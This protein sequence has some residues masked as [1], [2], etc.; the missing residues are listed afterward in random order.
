MKRGAEMRMITI[1]CALLVLTVASCRKS[2]APEKLWTVEKSAAKNGVSAIFRLS[3]VTLTPGARLDCELDVQAPAATQLEKPQLNL[4]G[5]ELVDFVALPVSLTSTGGEE[6][7]FRWTYQAG[8]PGSV[9][10]PSVCVNFISAQAANSLS[11]ELPAI[12]IKSA[13]APG[14]FTD[15]LPPLEEKNAF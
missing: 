7:K 8:P 3:A 11:I 1:A 5:T 12:T 14:T 6:R 4:P 15:T 13:F 9:A 10:N 2:S